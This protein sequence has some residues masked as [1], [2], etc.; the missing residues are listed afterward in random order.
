MTDN[1]RIPYKKALNP[2]QLEAVYFTEGPLLV[3][4]G[5]GSGKTRT[6]T[7]RVARLVEKGVSSNSILL[8]TFTRKASQEMLK[9]AASLLDSRCE[10]VAGGTFHS[11][12]YNVLQRYA[13]RI[14][15]D[16]GISIMDR[17]DSEDLI[18]LLRKEMRL[19]S[20]YGSFPRK[21]TLMN[22]ISRSVNKALPIEDVVLNDYPHFIHYLD[23]IV[24]LSKGYQ[25]QK[26]RYHFLDYDDLLVCLNRLLK[27]HPDVR[28]RMSS[29]YRYIMIDEYQDTN[30]IQAEIIYLLAYIN[31]NVMVVGDDSQ[32]I[33]SFRGASFENIMQFPEK[34]PEARIIKLEENYRSVQPILNLTNVII[35]RAERKYSKNLY[36]RKTSGSLPSLV[37]AKNEK[38]QSRFVIEKIRKLRMDGVALNEIAVLFRAG[39]HS[40]DLEVELNRESI[41]FI[42][43]GGFKF[44]ESAHIKDVLAHLRVFTNPYDRISW[45][46]IL[47][48]IN[49]IG[50][51]TALDIYQAIR[52]EKIGYKGLLDIKIKP[53]RKQ[54]LKHL[55][56]L[57]TIIDPRTFPVEEIGE[58]VLKYYTPIVKYK[59][60]DYPRRIRDIEQL[61]AMMKSYSNLEQFLTDM[62]LEPPNTSLNNTFLTEYPQDDQLVLST[63]HSAK[64]LEWQTVFIIWAL[65]G[66]FPSVHSL[67]C[68]DELEEELRL[69]Y[70]AATRAKENLF[71]IFPMHLYDRISN[72]PMNRPSRFID[73]ISDELLEKVFC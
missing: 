53:I 49:K 24:A 19:T 35:D 47:L 37:Y 15:F 30:H 52:D 9:R 21:Q 8:L 66:R 7:Y 12:A 18:G 59:Y 4:A 62:A 67:N 17:S 60:D 38:S 25:R 6:L 14:G 13:S 2:S 56:D 28:D 73:G 71:F 5:A 34:F 10:Q 43:V 39:F 61:I 36:T 11:F 20:K 32:S 44:V 50:P 3:I 54:H 41:P 31:K 63:V 1:F 64:G 45:Y 23:T 40:F 46:R 65:D 72:M 33:Y 48:L 58:T 57:Y 70:V 55:M 27:E 16:N 69:M 42:K 51:K 22:I 68:N 26:A 29:F